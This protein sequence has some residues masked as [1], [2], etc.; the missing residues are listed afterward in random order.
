MTPSTDHGTTLHQYL[1]VVRRRKWIILSITLLAAVLAFLH[2]VQQTPQYEASAK[3]LLSRTNLANSLTG[4]QD[5]NIFFD[6]QTLVKTQAEFARA[7]EIADRVVTKLGLDTSPGELLAHSSV[8]TSPSSD[9]L[10]FSVSNSDPDLAAKEATEYA[11]QYTSYRHERDTAALKSAREE[12]R[13]RIDQLAA[14]G[15]TQG[16]LYA[17][18]VRQEQRLQTM[19]ALQTSNATVIQTADSASKVS[20]TPVSDTVK[21]FFLGLILGLGVAFLVEGL[22]TRLRSASEISERLGLPLLGRIPSPSKEQGEQ[23]RLA[24]L[25]DPS[26]LHAESFRMLRTNL[27]FAMVDHTIRSILITS[28]VEKEGKSTTVANLAV[29]FARAGKRVTLVDLDLRKP[30]LDRFFQLTGRPGIM[31]VLCGRPLE[32]AL[33]SVPIL[34]NAGEMENGE[35]HPVQVP[36]VSGN[37]AGGTLEVL[38]AGQIPP[39]PGELIGSEALSNILAQL[40]E[41]CDLILIDSPPLLHV[42]DPM[43]LSA[44]VDAVVVVAR[45]QLLR[46]ST[47]TEAHRLLSTVRASKLGFVLTAS[48]AESGY[49]YGYGHGYRYSD[50]VHQ[51][52]EPVA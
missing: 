51:V 8:S 32:E 30:R 28:A 38:T 33:M 39:N 40:S 29:A 46:R 15:E 6:D 9:I 35:I 42:G 13:R 2:A 37:G 41:R 34:A 25:D 44:K 1:E 4:V 7:P 49:G 22:D 11:R 45:L 43:T 20:P 24:M 23:N 18:L 50:R 17:S 3:V 47:V 5:P 19:E 10:T 26:G 36:T 52:E 31:E 14:G 27:E 12:V 16:P 48:D 21:G